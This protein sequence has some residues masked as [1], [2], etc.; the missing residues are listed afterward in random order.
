MKSRRSWLVGLALGA[1]L[2]FGT[3]SAKAQV[4]RGITYQGLL[5]MNGSPYNNTT[6]GVQLDFTFADSTGTT[7]L[8]QSTI[9]GVPVFNGIFNVVL[10]GG[11]GGPE[12]P[13]TMNFNQQYSMSITVTVPGQPAFTLPGQQLFW[14]APYALNAERVGGIE[15]SNSPTNGK[16]FPLPLTGGK[17]DTSLIPL[18]TNNLLQ[19]S[20]I[21]TI[22]SQGPDANGNFLITGA[23]GIT[24]TPGTNGVV[25]GSS[26]GAGQLTGVFGDNGVTGGG[27]SGNVFL[28]IGSGAITANMIAPGAISGQK[29]T[30]IAGAGLSQDQFGLLNVNVDNA[31]IGITSSNAGNYLQVLPGGI[32]TLQLANGSV[33]NAKLA[34]PFID[35]TSS[36]GTLVSSSPQP[37]QLGGTQN[38]DLNLGHSNDWTVTQSFHSIND[39][40]MVSNVGALNETGATTML[41]SL[42]QSMGNVNL[43]SAGTS[44]NTFAVGASGSSNS[45]TFYGPLTQSNGNVSMGTTSGN[46]VT[47]GN[48][49]GSTMITGSLSQTTGNVSFTPGTTNTFMVTNPSGTNTITGTTNINATGNG[50]TNIGS[51]GSTNGITGV[52][53]INTTGNDATN[54]GSTNA[55][56]M[57]TIDGDVNAGVSANSTVNNFGTAGNLAAVTNVFGSTVAGSQNTINGAN[58]ITGL[59]TLQ[60]S[61]SAVN[62]NRLIING[63]VSPTPITSSSD[64]EFIVNGDGQVTGTLNV[65]NLT[66]TTIGAVTGAF[67]N[68]TTFSGGPTINVMKGMTIAGAV[69]ANNGLT[70][71]NGFTV[72]SGAITLSP[73]PTGVLH[74]N[75]GAISSSPVDLTTDVTGV[76]PI[77]NGG[78]NGTA[79]PALGQVAYGNGTA[80]DFTTG[81]TTGQFLQYNSGSAPTWVSAPNVLPS[82]TIVGNTLYWTGTQW[83]PTN[84]LNNNTSTLTVNENLTVSGGNTIFNAGAATVEFSNGGNVGF[85]NTGNLT[86]SPSG[87]INGTA[88]MQ[89]TG[90]AN[91]FSGDNAAA[92]LTLS[93]LSGPALNVTNGGTTFNANNVSGS[94]FTITGGSIDGTP[95]GATTPSTG[96]FTDLSATSTAN[97]TGATTTIT[98]GSIDGTPIGATTPS[99]GA[100]TGLMNTGLFTQTGTLNLSGATSPLELNGDDGTSGYFLVSNGAGATPSYSDVLPPTTTI[101]FSNI[102]SGT[103]TV[104]AMVV[105][106]GASLDYTG[107]TINSSSLEGNTWESPGTIGSTTPNSGAFTDLS[108][109]STAN[110]TGAT[111]TITGGTIDNTTIGVTTPADG[112][113]TTIGATTPGSGAFTD[114]SATSTANF[115]GAT[116]TI[117]GGSIDGTPIGATTPSTGGFTDLTATSTANFTG[118]TTT[119]TGGSIDGTPIGATTPSTGGFTDLTATS[120]ANF[121]GAT[122]TI[123]GGSIDGTPIGAT[124]PSTGAFTDLSATSTANFTGATTTITGGSIDGT[125]IGATTPSTGAFTGLMN[126]GLFTQTGTLNLSGA[127]SP[128]ELNGDDGTS[129]YFLVS[130]GAGATPSYSDVLPPTTTISFSNITSGTN[131]VAA[132]VVGAGASLDY[133]G[134]TINSSSLEGNTWESPG[135][136]GSTTPN[137][138]KFTTLESTGNSMIGDGAAATANS[139]GTSGNAAAVTNTIGSNMAGSATNFFG[140]VTMDGTNQASNELAISNVT[141]GHWGESITAA[142]ASGNAEGLS[143]TATATSGTATALKANASGGTS[144]VGLDVTSTGTGSVGV[145]VDAGSLTGISV[146]ASTNTGNGVL[147]NSVTSNGNGLNVNLKSGGVS[148]TNSINI[149]LANGSG[150]GNNGVRVQNLSNASSHGVDI[151]MSA[152]TGINETMTANGT[153][154]QVNSLAAA[155]GISLQGLSSGTGISVAGP[156]SNGYGI[157]ITAP[158][159]ASGA[160]GIRVAGDGSAS[161][162]AIEVSAGSVKASGSGSGTSGSPSNKF[163]DTYVLSGADQSSG[164][165]TIYNNLVTVGSTIIITEKTNGGTLGWMTVSA[166]TTGNFT[167]STT[168]GGGTPFGGVDDIYYEIINH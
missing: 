16:L 35:F 125:P 86:L 9:S 25:I 89:M 111:T 72:S 39:T 118:A 151:T 127:T 69:T 23:N 160:T 156:T 14:S 117:T 13:S 88:S 101:S 153:A 32:G 63:I 78:T 20:Y 82:G 30:G 91:S 130:N 55:G 18:I 4:P 146:D 124:T 83:L 94:N 99:T 77:A 43:L 59:T 75:S 76:L 108:A 136:I 163:A 17:I 95:I 140:S 145:Q 31:T 161:T 143:S 53:N 12:F 115:T 96:A 62:G 105:G 52:T 1:A 11:V 65:G 48:T 128:L 24:V 79:L 27:T 5:E 154:M 33:T 92:E 2:F 133:T 138:G 162:T 41:G 123:T 165:V 10:P 119:I 114:L 74:S 166:Q 49:T 80:Y 66:A 21:E 142:P 155:Q 147:I 50:N 134:G 113:F 97:F 87:V 71:S 38:Y 102:T 167:V 139:F 67:D 81:G 157:N 93:N 19:N 116:T 42:N 84:S 106:A 121:T 64:Y 54:I 149:D 56:S 3:P 70:V 51:S 122:T 159:S 131:T 26:G 47:L 150:G 158:S 44:G 58:E 98:G 29:I 6:P 28:G 135:T 129:G 104:A 22:N 61:P 120:T 46:T 144:N 7:V 90:S 37:T 85:Q 112:N 15:V 73:L 141:G 164:T 168:N 68:L 137:T 100:F 34:N 40:G 107:G 109:T 148:N 60:A 103:N 110:F 57:T 8:Y 126:T 36:G 132:M 45:S 152:G